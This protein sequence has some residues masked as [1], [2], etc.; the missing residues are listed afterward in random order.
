MNKLSVS[1]ATFVIF[2]FR[3]GRHF[4]VILLPTIFGLSCRPSVASL[5]VH[6]IVGMVMVLLVQLLWPV[7]EGQ[8]FVGFQC[9]VLRVLFVVLLVSVL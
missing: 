5:V 2:C 6:D 9:F 3:L 1:S 4:L 8:I 7:F